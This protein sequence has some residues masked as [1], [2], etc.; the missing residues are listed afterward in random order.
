MTSSLLGEH[1][2]MNEGSNFLHLSNSNYLVICVRFCTG[3]SN[4]SIEHCELAAIT[5]REDVSQF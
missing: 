2:G 1:A 4:I 5:S 3:L